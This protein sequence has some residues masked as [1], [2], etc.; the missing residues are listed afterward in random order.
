M[1]L[2]WKRG[3]IRAFPHQGSSLT[4]RI[5][6]LLFLLAFFLPFQTRMRQLRVAVETGS[7]L[8]QEAARPDFLRS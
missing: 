6:L 3:V 1:S 7:I 2:I 4:E 5:F 8:P